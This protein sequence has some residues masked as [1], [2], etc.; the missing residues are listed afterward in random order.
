MAKQS[1]YRAPSVGRALAILEM[2]SESGAGLGISELARRLELS[3]GTVFGL[4]S[5]LEAG[6]ALARDPAS[7]RFRLGPLAATLASRGSVHE[8]LREAAGPEMT[9]L[10]D[11][12]GESVFLGVM[13]RGEITVIE[14]RQPTG[15]VGVSAGPGTRLPLSAG[16]VGL[17]LLAGLPPAALERALARGLKAYTPHTL[18]DPAALAARLEEVRAQGYAVESEEYLSGVWGVAVPLGAAAGLPAAL[19]VAGFTSGLAPGRLQEV[20]ARLGKAREAV[21]QSLASG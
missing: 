14:A 21:A 1:G 5:Q 9:R 12:L 15:T 11:G 20:A 4:C 8:R 19:W 17:V 6:G 16:A 10:R 18:T 7:K 13:G 2:V 3:K